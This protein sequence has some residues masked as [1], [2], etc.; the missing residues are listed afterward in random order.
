MKKLSVSSV[1]LGL[2]ATIFG[3]GVSYWAVTEFEPRTYHYVFI[4]AGLVAAIYG[5]CQG[6][7]AIRLGRISV[8]RPF[9]ALLMNT[10]GMVATLYGFSQAFRGLHYLPHSWAATISFLLVAIGLAGALFGF[11]R[12]YILIVTMLRVRPGWNTHV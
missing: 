12:A 3:F 4:T 8:R 1:A 2:G 5:F 7:R 10:L 9:I 6:F 11:I